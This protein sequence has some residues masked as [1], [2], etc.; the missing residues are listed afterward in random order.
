MFAYLLKQYLFFFIY[1]MAQIKLVGYSLYISEHVMNGVNLLICPWPSACTY[2][3][4]YFAAG[5]PKSTELIVDFG[6]S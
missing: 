1:L 6:S 4:Q 3:E 2:V 5:R